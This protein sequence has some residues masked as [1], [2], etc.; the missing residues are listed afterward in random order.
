M[1]KS[2]S[3]LLGHGAINKTFQQRDADIRVFIV[4]A[5]KKVVGA[6]TDAE[7][8]KLHNERTIALQEEYEALMNIDRN[9][10]FF[11]NI[12]PGWNPTPVP[13]NS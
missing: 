2:F 12:E 8:K 11:Q 6:T 5:Q 9:S 1:Q 3:Y 7:R 13:S 4:E 10:Y